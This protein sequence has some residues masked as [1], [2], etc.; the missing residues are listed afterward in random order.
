MAEE[1]KQSVRTP[2]R[3]RRIYFKKSELNT[4]IATTASEN[5]IVR[6]HEFTTVKGCRTN[7]ANDTRKLF[8]TRTS[9]TS[10][11]NSKVVSKN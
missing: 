8:A 9:F 11:F 5:S 10:K 1:P 3:H 6:L 4:E 7:L 2:G